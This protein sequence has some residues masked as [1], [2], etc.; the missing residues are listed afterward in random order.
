MEVNRPTL[1]LW[2]SFKSCGDGQSSAA[3]IISESEGVTL[4]FATACVI[5]HF[6]CGF[7]VFRKERTCWKP[8]KLLSKD[9]LYVVLALF[10][11]LHVYYTCIY[12]NN[13]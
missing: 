9:I 4:V 2:L 7:S 13:N 11:R 5:I 1:S 3:K 6:I 10:Y 12:Y 8:V